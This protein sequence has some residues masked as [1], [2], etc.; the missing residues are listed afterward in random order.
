MSGAGPDRRT[1]IARWRRGTTH[2][3]GAAS[4]RNPK[5]GTFAAFRS[6][7]FAHRFIARILLSSRVMTRVVAQSRLVL[8]LSDNALILGPGLHVHPSSAPDHRALGRCCRRSSEHSATPSDD[9]DRFRAHLVGAR[10]L[11]VTHTINVPVIL[12]SAL[13]SGFVMKRL[14]DLDYP[15]NIKSA[16]RIVERTRPST[17]FC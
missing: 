9:P 4:G 14:V 5:E 3:D 7:L 11:T 8:Q 16:K 1:P 13:I 6:R 17:G 12:V 15:Q 10:V 2:K